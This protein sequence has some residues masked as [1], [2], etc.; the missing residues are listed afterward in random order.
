MVSEACHF[1]PPAVARNPCNLG[2]LASFSGISRRYAPRN[3]IP[4]TYY[5][6]TTQKSK[7][8]GQHNT[9]GVPTVF[10]ASA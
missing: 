3:D 7:T 9:E 10:L 6:T 5:L 1:E 8:R 2:L 4:I